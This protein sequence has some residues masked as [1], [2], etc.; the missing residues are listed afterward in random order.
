[1]PRRIR[2]L[3]IGVT[4]A[5]LQTSPGPIPTGI[6]GTPRGQYRLARPIR[7]SVNR[8]LQVL[9]PDH[10]R[11]CSG[12]VEARGSYRASRGRRDRVSDHGR[13]GERRPGPREQDMRADA[14]CPHAFTITPGSLAAV[15]TSSPGP[16][17]RGT[18]GR[19]LVGAETTC[20]RGV[21]GA[22]VGL[23][24]SPHLLWTSAILSNRR[25][26]LHTSSR[27]DLVPPGVDRKAEPG[28]RASSP[29]ERARPQS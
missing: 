26:Q 24:R 25:C 8:G 29:R 18:A 16:S 13:P 3:A 5:A 2:T 15:V 28:S 22:P 21:P 7:V 10:A 19:T 11:T 1:M 27:Q 6:S 20:R 9:A 4:D 14:T 17:D 12:T 23:R